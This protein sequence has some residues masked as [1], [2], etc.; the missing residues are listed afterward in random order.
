MNTGLFS[1]FC[2]SIDK[3]IDDGVLNNEVKRQTTDV[4]DGELEKER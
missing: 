2:T 1:L 3:Y 4:T